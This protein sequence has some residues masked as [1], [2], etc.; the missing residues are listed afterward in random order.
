MGRE[1]ASEPDQVIPARLGKFVGRTNERAKLRQLVAAGT[2]LITVTGLSG[3]GKTRLVRE[4]LGGLIDAW[5]SASDIE[6]GSSLRPTVEQRAEAL[7][8]K[9]VPDHQLIVLDSIDDDSVGRDLISALDRFPGLQVII[10]SRIRMHVRGEVL[11]RL[12]PL[13]YPSS[14]DDVDATEAS[15]WEA[16]ECFVQSAQRVRTDFEL[17]AANLGSVVELL[18][19]TGGLPLAIDLVANWLRVTDVDELANRV[20]NSFE[21][22]T[23][24]PADLPARQRDLRKSIQSAIDELQPDDRE[25]LTALAQLGAVSGEGLA[26]GLDRNVPLT[27]LGRLVD[28]NLIELTDSH[29]TGILLHPMVRRVA[30]EQ[31]PARDGIQVRFLDWL[32]NELAQTTSLLLTEQ[33]R[34]AFERVDKLHADVTAALDLLPAEPSTVAATIAYLCRYWEFSYQ[35]RLLLR[36]TTKALEAVD[37]D[38]HLATALHI[39]ASKAYRLLLELEHADFHAGSALALAR[40]SGDVESIATALVARLGCAELAGKYGAVD[41]EYQEA[42]ALCRRHHLN[43]ILGDVYSIGAEYLLSSGPTQEAL[44]VAKSGVEAALGSGNLVRQAWCW[45]VE[46]WAF[47]K[48]GEFDAAAESQRQALLAAEPLHARCGIDLAVYLYEGDTLAAA[49]RVREGADRMR[50]VVEGLERL[51]LPIGL[52]QSTT[53]W[54]GMLAELGDHVEARRQ[55]KRSLELSRGLQDRMGA[56]TSLVAIA[57]SGA[58]VRPELALCDQILTAAAAAV[59][60]Y[61]EG[62]SGHWGDRLFARRSEISAGRAQP[63]AGAPQSTLEQL[64]GLTLQHLND[65]EPPARPLG[66]SAREIDVLRHLAVGETDGEIAKSLVIGTRTVNTHVSAVLRKLGVERRRQAAAWARA[67]LDLERSDVQGV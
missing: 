49:G 4:A 16:V 23:G 22:F 21:P 51:E 54:A 56:W 14:P 19:L 62:Q 67:N 12:E 57:I 27:S 26:H 66:L 9:A 58:E 46:S 30:A 63:E 5:I 60:G 20:R 24:G 31:S 40:R 28:R 11:L 3:V 53:L 36:W 2:P 15:K 39:G 6:D 65:A 44:Q 43:D 34:P 42:I 48:L 35:P 32:N 41:Q 55:F 61:L 37:D 7:L 29:T 50:L 38:D 18:E 13:R 52:I 1:L 17:T 64:V 45:L 10:T 33:S 8:T 25:V 59:P 47:T